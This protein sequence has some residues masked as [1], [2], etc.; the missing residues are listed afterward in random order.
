[1]ATVTILPSDRFGNASFP[2]S[3]RQIG[4]TAQSGRLQGSLTDN[5]DASFTQ[6]LVVE[7]GEEAAVTVTVGGVSL[8]R[9]TSGGVDGRRELSLHAGTAVP[10]GAFAAQ[11][12][13]GPTF[14]LDFVHRFDAH[15]AVRAELGISRFADE[16]EQD[17]D[18]VNLDAYLQYRWG[19]GLWTPYFEAG[20]GFYDLRSG[21]SGPGFAVG[22]GVLR[23]LSPNVNLDLAIHGHRVGGGLDIDYSQIRAGVLF[24]F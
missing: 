4:V 14:S 23:H 15:L 17:L 11:A 19:G 21:S 5:F 7:E 2:G 24:K 10:H 22:L 9:H 8:G 3:G 20:L 1:V 6:E 13:P 18:L 12:D 16:D